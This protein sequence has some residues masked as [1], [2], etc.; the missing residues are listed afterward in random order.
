M[1]ESDVIIV[2]IVLFIAL[3]VVIVAYISARHRERMSMI[4]KGMSSDD[5]KALY[6]REIR[7]NPLGSL[8][9]GILLV[10]AGLAVLVGNY[11]HA[12]YYVDEG[13]VIGLICLFVGIGLVLFYALAA[14]K[15]GT[16]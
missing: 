7:R 16:P 3:A 9:W 12:Q 14:K 15:V 8:K 13:V 10:M 1:N 11:L 6:A 5:I 4:D 2:P